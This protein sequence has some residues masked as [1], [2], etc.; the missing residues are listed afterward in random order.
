MMRSSRRASLVAAVVMA[1]GCGGGRPAPAPPTP[2][3]AVAAAAIDGGAAVAATVDAS[4]PAPP[5]TVGA[6]PG[7]PHMAP[8]AA[9]VLARRGD[10]ALSIDAAGE[11]RLW[12]ALDGSAAPRRVTASGLVDPRV[13]RA[14]DV[15]LVGGVL[16]GGVGYL[17]RYR[18]TG[19]P[20]TEV[21][22]DGADG[23]VIA[24]V[25]TVDAGA[26]VVAR[27]DQVLELVDGDGRRRDRVELAHERLRGLTASGPAAVVAVLRRADD[28]FVARRY[29]VRGARLIADADVLLPHAPVDGAPLAMSPDDRRLA[30]FHHVEPEPPP[31]GAD[32]AKRLP[33]APPPPPPSPV[34][35]VQVVDLATAVDVTPA[36]LRG[37]VFDTASQL[38]FSSADR[39]RVGDGAGGV[40]AAA[41]DSADPLTSSV[42]VGIGPVAIADGVVIGS[43]GSAL[44]IQRDGAAPVYLGYRLSQPRWSALSASGRQ[45][46]VVGDEPF[47]VVDT[48]DGSAPERT[49]PLTGIAPSFVAFLDDERLIVLDPAGHLEVHAIATGALLAAVTVGPT[50]VAALH[51]RRTW[52][53]GL[54]D[55]GGLWAVRL[56]VTGDRPLGAPIV[57][58][59]RSSFLA[60]VDDGHA[61]GPV[62]ATLVGGRIEAYT[63][64]RLTGAPA[65]KRKRKPPA[66]SVSGNADEV[67]HFYGLLG[68]TVHA[69]DL[70]GTARPIAIGVDTGNLSALPDGGALVSTAAA[71]GLTAYGLDGRVRWSVAIGPTLQR[72]AAS[73]DRRLLALATAGGIAI[74]DAASGENLAARCAWRFGAWSD[75]PTDIPFGTINL[76]R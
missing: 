65:D 51:P 20:P 46:A 63:E 6:P 17:G 40:V 4:Q 61:D 44:A 41:L 58:G 49:V 69:T 3:V 5:A 25:P 24:V 1:T 59:D 9:A 68:Q 7:V 28:R 34:V 70:A 64:A 53:F 74:V 16:P 47:A 8:I 45:L 66:V 38:G 2:D 36:A 35:N 50:A 72:V 60:V 33:G 43:Q 76:C 37:H 52:L 14:G 67:G 29:R 73:A 21:T 48:L 13:E 31:A 32:P 26:A 71:G 19:G 18:A 23:D 55:A 22:V 15:I 11:V 57:I 30:T 39:L 12:T 10:A 75:A 27:A 54:Q 62:V 56:A 42:G